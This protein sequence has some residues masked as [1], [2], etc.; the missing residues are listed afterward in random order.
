MTNSHFRGE[1]ILQDSPRKYL[2]GRIMKTL[3]VGKDEVP[4][5]NKIVNKRGE[6]VKQESEVLV[7]WSRRINLAKG[8]E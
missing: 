3:W 1:K 5:K 6:N 4:L 8:R 2:Q 7:S